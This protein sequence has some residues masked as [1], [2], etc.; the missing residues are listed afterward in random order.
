MKQKTVYC[1]AAYKRRLFAILLTLSLLAPESDTAKAADIWKQ[2]AGKDAAAQ[3][4][5]DT[6]IITLEE[7]R[8]GE[9]LLDE[10]NDIATE[11]YQDYSEL[12]EENI[13]V[14]QA[15]ED[16]VKELRKTDGV[17]CVEEDII[18][19]GSK[20]SASKKSNKEAE[21]TLLK[22]KQK[23]IAEWKDKTSTE[24]TS[25][26][27]NIQMV[28]AD[29]ISDKEYSGGKTTDSTL[30]EPSPCPVKIAVIDSGMD[31][32][33]HYD[34]KEHINFVKE[35][36]NVAL[37]YE[38]RTGHGTAIAGIIA[39][40]QNGIPGINPDAELY[41]L[42][43]LDENN[44]SPASRIVEAIHWCIGHDIQ[45]INMSFGTPLDSPA[46]RDAVTQAANAGILM[47]AAAGNTGGSVEYPAAYKQVMAVGSIDS[48][49]EVS[50]YSCEGSS[51]EILAPGE[52]IIT[53]GAFSGVTIACGTSMSVPHV[54]GAASLIWQKDPARSAAF[55]RELLKASAKKMEGRDEGI[56]DVEYA[57]EQYD[58]FKENYIEDDSI[59]K[60]NGADGSTDRNVGNKEESIPTEE[61]GIKENNSEVE[62]F[63][64]DN[65]V[66]GSWM[67]EEHQKSVTEG[68]AN[69]DLIVDVSVIRSFV[70]MAD[71]QGKNAENGY[72]F[73]DTKGLHGGGNYV[74]NLQYLFN[75]A[76]RVEE[77]KSV[78]TA[79]ANTKY[80]GKQDAK[81]N[82]KIT[83]RE[84]KKGLDAAIKAISN[85]GKNKREK[86]Q[87]IL[88]LAFHLAGDIYAHESMVPKSSLEKVLTCTDI[89]KMSYFSKK[90]F[91]TAKFKNL[92]ELVNDGVLKF[93]NINEGCKKDYKS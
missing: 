75:V 45:I 23:K 15:D 30:C 5:T 1:R 65:L 80:K 34:V 22:K 6:Y 70:H 48:Q 37:C 47:I 28:G 26:S 85:N 71:R 46:L 11:E 89:V 18:L 43:V 56:L 91:S 51:V 12:P 68:L 67:K 73:K 86:S 53:E 16:T 58:T 79:I 84:I 52:K 50:G 32:T 21:R 77:G 57:L 41:S 3:T 31:M 61:Y 40:N 35:D 44:Q 24:N 14:I 90:H 93:V 39:G 10:L 27:W 76:K 2:P 87:R 29:G 55:V 74:A 7:N 17:R 78:A 13:A 83:G 9:A 25:A 4:R 59:G 42:K 54:T 8:Q 38:D 92:K 33:E 64:T 49:G 63:D 19:N 72:N 36:E 62:T 60:E 88:A 81:E 82:S 69:T 66:E 20:K